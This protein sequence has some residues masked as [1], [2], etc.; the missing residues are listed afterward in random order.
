[1]SD[2]LELLPCPFCGVSGASL[3]TIKQNTQWKVYCHGC[4]A[5]GPASMMCAEDDDAERNEAR[6]EWNKAPRTN[7]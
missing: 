4:G 1:M 6:A 3:A 7:P 5:M 2:R